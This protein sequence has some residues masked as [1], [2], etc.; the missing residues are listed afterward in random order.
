[1]RTLEQKLECIKKA[2]INSQEHIESGDPPR[3]YSQ[4]MRYALE[5]VSSI[6]FYISN[7]AIGLK[8][9]DVIHEH[10]VPHSFVMN[11]LLSL[12][13]VTTEE[14]LNIVNK[15]FIICVVTRQEDKLL[16]SA[17]LRTKM[18]EGWD[19]ENGSMFARYE[20]VGIEYQE[21]T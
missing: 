6:N 14:I 13:P 8:R 10:V 7:N 3:I 4:Y 19:E 18:P 12:N 15:Y 11:K 16:N 5:Q 2:V 21:S 20:A 1:M 17:G 9:K